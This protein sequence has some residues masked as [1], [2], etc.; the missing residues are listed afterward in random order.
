MKFRIYADT[1]VI[2]GVFD[3][4][5]EEWSK[6]LIDNFKKGRNT[7][8]LSDLTLREIEEA[9]KKVRDIVEKIPKKHK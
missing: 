5:F 6:Q 1:S 9:P 4:E 3:K 8:V 2:G 7:I